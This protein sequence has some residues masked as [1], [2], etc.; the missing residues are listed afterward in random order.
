MVF[1]ALALA[2]VAYPVFLAV[3][4]TVIFLPLSLLV[5]L[6]WYLL[7]PVILK[8]LRYHWYETVG[9]GDHVPRTAVS[10]FPAL[11]VPRMVGVG[12][13]ENSKST[14]LATDVAVAVA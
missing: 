8:P 6:Y 2:T 14:V 11:A 4:L 7:A 12:R 1:E 5:S 9:V 13:F 10:V 3:T